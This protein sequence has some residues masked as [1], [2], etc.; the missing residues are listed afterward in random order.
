MSGAIQRIGDSG[1]LPLHVTGMD[2]PSSDEVIQTPSL[3]VT[4]E[5]ADQSA[6]VVELDSTTSRAIHSLREMAQNVVA[7]KLHELCDS[8]GIEMVSLLK[9][10]RMKKGVGREYTVH[11]LLNEYSDQTLDAAE[12]ALKASPKTPP[13]D[14]LSATE[15]V[16][17]TL[18]KTADS[19][20]N[21]VRIILVDNHSK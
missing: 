7:K 12:D 13:A 21:P 16:I 20:L 3:E 18:D 11:S 8:F 9:W 4:T 19:V 14:L 6:E 2:M 5:P 15:R 17:Q 10:V 1:E